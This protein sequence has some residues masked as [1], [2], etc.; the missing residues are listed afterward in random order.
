M[1]YYVSH[2][3]WFITPEKELCNSCMVHCGLFLDRPFIT[4]KV[5]LWVSRR[6]KTHVF[7]LCT[8]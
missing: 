4:R 7:F 6:K 8:S 3:L 5:Y 1:V 2:E